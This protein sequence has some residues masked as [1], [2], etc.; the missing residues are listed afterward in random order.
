LNVQRTRLLPSEHV[1][2]T[3]GQLR[4]LA[5]IDVPS[6]SL[7][8]FAEQRIALLAALARAVARQQRVRCARL[9]CLLL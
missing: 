9:A 3:L 6:S 8:A 7:N 1:A 4:E 5:R 2:A